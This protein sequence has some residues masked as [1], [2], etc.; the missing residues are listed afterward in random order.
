MTLNVTSS[1]F[2]VSWSLS[3]PQSHTFHVQVY[4]GEE[5]LRSARTRGTT[6]EVAGLEAGVLYRV[7]TSYQRC[8]AHV[9]AALTVRTGK[10]PHPKSTRYL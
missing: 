9:T 1:S 2:H 5:L 4:K 10:P 7:K 6:L 8:G 3:S